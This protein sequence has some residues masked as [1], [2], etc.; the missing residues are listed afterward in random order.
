MDQRTRIAIM[1]LSCI[2]RRI[3]AK[4][5]DLVDMGTLREDATITMCMLQM[6]MPPS[7]FD[8]MVHLILHLVDEPNMCGLVHT[9]WMYCVERLN[10]VL[11][12]Y[13]HN[14]AQLEASMV[15]GYL[16][17]ETLGLIIEYMNHFQPSKRQLW[18][19]DEEEGV[20]GE[21]LKGASTRIEIIITQRNMAH[22]YVL[23]NTNIM[24]PWVRWNKHLKPTHH[25]FNVLQC[26]ILLLCNYIGHKKFDMF[27][28][29]QL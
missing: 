6:T 4:V 8:T 27:T 16:V 1:C 19:S 9:R 24:A 26:K 12:G 23:N 18:D 2:F 29:W 10:K 15:T 13:V 20:C 28:L 3:C 11:K 22:N 25:M 21:V 14:M 7:F 5:L 17:D